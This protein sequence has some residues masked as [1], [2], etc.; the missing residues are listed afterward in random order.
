M[1]ELAYCDS[2]GKDKKGCVN[3]KLIKGFAT[4]CPECLVDL[5]WTSAVLKAG[6]DWLLNKMP[7]RYVRVSKFVLSPID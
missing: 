6:T 3:K 7:K 5:K 2:C 1:N 4:L